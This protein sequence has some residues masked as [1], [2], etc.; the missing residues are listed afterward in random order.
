MKGRVKEAAGDLTG[1]ER[2]KNEGAADQ[3]EGKVQNAWGKGKERIGEAMNDA[4]KRLKR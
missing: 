3:A 2:L 1:N 4:G